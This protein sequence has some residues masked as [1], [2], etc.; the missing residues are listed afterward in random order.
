VLPR[1][2]AGT[3][4]QAREPAA[5]ASRAGTR[6]A[7]RLGLI[8]TQWLGSRR[9][10]GRQHAMA[11]RKM[12]PG[13]RHVCDE[14]LDQFM[15]REQCR[16]CAFAAA[17]ADRVIPRAAARPRAVAEQPAGRAFVHCP[18]PGPLPGPRIGRPRQAG[19][20]GPSGDCAL[21][22]SDIDFGDKRATRSR[23]IIARGT[24]STS[25]DSGGTGR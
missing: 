24:R 6:D 5:P 19:P 21:P 1:T 12:P 3:G 11:P 23:W 20:E 17:L 2:Y 9:E 16:M 13:P 22:F 4:R 10:G 14:Q 18:V 8:V 7:G 25:T 15:W